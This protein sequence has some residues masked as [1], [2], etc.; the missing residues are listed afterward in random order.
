MAA[1]TSPE[2]RAVSSGAGVVVGAPR[3]WLGLEG[4]GLPGMS[5]GRKKLIV[6]AAIAVT[7]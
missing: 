1:S 2:Q 6:I 5:R 3:W 4:L 7:M